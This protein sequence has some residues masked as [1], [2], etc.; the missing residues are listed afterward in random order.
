MAGLAGLQM[1]RR[2]NA[3]YSGNDGRAGEAA[4]AMTSGAGRT[5]GTEV[6][7]FGL[8]ELWMQRRMRKSIDVLVSKIH[9]EL[10]LITIW[11]RANRFS[12][13]LVEINFILS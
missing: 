9:I 6:T 3:R 5:G 4:N 12:M 7:A 8:A 11:S 10:Q 13:N 2:S 1:Q